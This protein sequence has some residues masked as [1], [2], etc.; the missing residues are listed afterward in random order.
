M[1]IT[2]YKSTFTIDF[3]KDLHEDK[4][5]LL[6]PFGTLTVQVAKHYP[7]DRYLFIH[8]NFT[9]FRVSQV[10]PKSEF[11]GVAL[12]SEKFEALFEYD[13]SIYYKF[14]LEPVDGLTF[15]PQQKA[16]AIFVKSIDNNQFTDITLETEDGTRQ[17]HAHRLL[18]KEYTPHFET[19]LRNKPNSNKVIVNN[20]QFE[21]Y[22]QIIDFIYHGNI[23]EEQSY[24]DMLGLYKFVRRC[25]VKLMYSPLAWFVVDKY[26]GSRE[27]GADKVLDWE[28]YEELQWYMCHKF[29]WNFGKDECQQFIGNAGILAQLLRYKEWSA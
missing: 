27:E 20:E 23:N 28:E 14:R 3:P 15:N 25:G 29:Q 24:E 12:R 16:S 26:R 4:K 8:Q 5:T 7:Y 13:R 11:F 22:Q 2:R 18:L 6:T 19:I 9:I 17:I 21:L 1:D 10:L